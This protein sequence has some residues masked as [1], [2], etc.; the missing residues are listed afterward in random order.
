MLILL[1]AAGIAAGIFVLAL[2][3]P[4]EDSYYPRCYFHYFTGL[5]C[6]G[7]GLTRAVHALLNG[8]I[9]QAFA[10]NAVALI[11]LPFVVWSLARSSRPAKCR[12]SA[13][14]RPS[15][16][17]VWNRLLLGAVLLYWV[18]RNLPWYPFTLLAPHEL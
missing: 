4:T 18:V 16:S 6:P 7:C 2:V 5:H 15:A 17:V 13:K 9:E 8:R 3:S 1:A 14:T 12:L 10:Y 11:V